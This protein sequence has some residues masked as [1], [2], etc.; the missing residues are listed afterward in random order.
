MLR[1]VF[2]GFPVQIHWLFW[3]TCAVLGGGFYARSLQDWLFVAVWTAVVFV[4][5]MVHELGHALVG[6]SYGSRPSILLHGLGGL[7]VLPG[8]RVTRW[9]SVLLSAAGPAAGLLLGV[10][11]LLLRPV[12]QPSEA[13]GHFAFG[14]LVY[15]NILWSLFNLLPVMPM[16]GGQI[17][18]SL[19]GPRRRR[20]TAV[21]GAVT[22]GVLCV[23]SLLAGQW[24]LAV[25]LGVLAFSNYRS[26]GQV[27]GGVHT[28]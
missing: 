26:T 4:S 6:R 2:A 5:I 16:D 24:I 25:F 23:L 14:S 7:T 19:L 3:V 13:L 28:P 20:V 10:V 18:G 1:F 12:L 8:L 9:R 22:A 15:V 17:L 11:A 21:V 27:P